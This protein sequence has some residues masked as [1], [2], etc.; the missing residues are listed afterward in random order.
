MITFYTGGVLELWVWGPR[1]YKEV[2]GYYLCAAII[3]YVIY[4]A[5]TDTCKY[6]NNLVELPILFK[7]I[8]IAI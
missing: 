4:S 7:N 3:L 2:K 8:A 6:I 5:C 1:G